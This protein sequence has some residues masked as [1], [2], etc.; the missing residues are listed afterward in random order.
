MFAALAL[1]AGMSAAQPPAPLPDRW[2]LKLAPADLPALPAR[3]YEPT[4]HDSQRA[5]AVGFSW[6]RWFHF[7]R[8]DAGGPATA[9]ITKQ[10]DRAPA[11][12]DEPPRRVVPLAVHGPLVEFD[13]RLYTAAVRPIRGPKQ[14]TDVLHLGAAVALPRNVWYQVGTQ[15]LRDGKGVAVVEWRL[16]FKDDPRTTASGTLTARHSRRPLA[17]RGSDAT[18]AEWR[19]VISQIREPDGGRAV[20]LYP[21]DSFTGV[22]P[23]LQLGGDAEPDRIWV[24]EWDRLR[25]TPAPRPAPAAPATDVPGLVRPPPAPR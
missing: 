15:T 5:A 13:G 14:A 4:W 24:H 10:R 20:N 16:E 19:F 3:F 17:E 18:A 8:P 11:P 22:R 1:A 12:G 6:D 7:R 2:L 23:L 21:P 25:L 9:T